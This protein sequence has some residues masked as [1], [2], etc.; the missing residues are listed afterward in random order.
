MKIPVADV[1]VEPDTS[2]SDAAD[3][4]TSHQTFFARA[5]IRGQVGR[6]NNN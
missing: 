1:A 3:Y 2:A 5:G 6:E 4:V